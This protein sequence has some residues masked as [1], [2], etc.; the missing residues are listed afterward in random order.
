[1]T[2][3]HP[4]SLSPFHSAPLAI[5]LCAGLAA[6]AIRQPEAAPAEPEPAAVPAAV[7]TPAAPAG[8]NAKSPAHAA[9]LASAAAIREAT[10]LSFTVTMQSEG[11]SFAQY[12][13]TFTAD[14][15]MLRDP[16][17]R[18]VW[19]VRSK[20]SGRLTPNDAET[21][22]EVT[23]SSNSIEWLDHAAKKYYRRPNGA[24]KG[25]IMQLAGA[26]RVR[27]FV[28]AA[29]LS[30]I[31]KAASFEQSGTESIDGVQCTVID[32]LAQRAGTKDRIAI[33]PDNIPRR[34]EMI[35]ESEM[36]AGRISANYRS[37]RVNEA[38][39][40]SEFRITPP[41][42]YE[43]DIVDNPAPAS[44]SKPAAGS[45]DVTSTDNGVTTAPG[46]THSATTAPVPVPAPIVPAGP[47][48]APDVSFKL[49]GQADATSVSLSSLKGNVV[50]LDFFGTWSLAAR[51][52][53]AELKDLLA[54]YKDKPVKLYSLAIREKTPEAASAYFAKQSLDWGAQGGLA[55]VADDLV[56]P[57]RIRS[58]PT[59]VVI[60]K[61]G[62]IVARI[63][64]FKRSTSTAYLAACIDAALDGKAV[65]P[66]PT[67]APVEAIP[68]VVVT[69]PDGTAINAAG[70]PAIANPAG[71]TKV[72]PPPS[73]AAAAAAANATNRPKA[74]HST[75]AKPA[76]GPDHTTVGKPTNTVE[77]RKAPDSGAKKDSV[78]DSPKK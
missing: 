69:A 77:P 42:G 65:P 33:G 34:I 51:P 72:A 61:D 2:N 10:S 70:K 58:Y 73:A 20:G 31:L 16:A 45:T 53:H 64:N 5:V 26:T 24:A 62:M 57:F 6:A 3:I 21:Q 38:M 40:P 43:S 60:D 63:G 27:E 47:E 22:F 39:D 14:V 25:K 71:G 7:P 46:T 50:I 74:P 30:K 18:N 1:M 19:L 66:E 15:K 67:E 29:P 36:L 28:E 13:P 9:V 11:S 44:T 68:D 32:G 49:A 59:F 75:S 76:T 17:N 78:K 23:W 56:S 48:P 4:R 35:L 55:P 37:V 52:A 8:S 41:D 12:T 54:R